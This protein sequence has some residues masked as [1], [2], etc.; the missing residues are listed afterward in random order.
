MKNFMSQQCALAAVKAKSIL[1]SI[2]RGMASRDREVIVPL[3]SALMKIHLEYC[4]QVWGPQHKKDEELLKRV[5]RR[6]MN[7]IQG[8]EYLCYEE[9]LKELGLFSL[10][11]R[12]LKE[13]LI[14]A[15]QYLKGVDKHEGKQLFTWVDRGRTRRNGFKLKE[16]NIRCQ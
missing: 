7:M 5:Q 11:N 12:R 16:I 8:L 10:E 9:R 15:F 14:M 3:Y 2:R 6:A 13:D 4:I 1:S